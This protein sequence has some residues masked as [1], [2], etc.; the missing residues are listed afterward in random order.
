M[1]A[2]VFGRGS[3]FGKIGRGKIFG[4]GVGQNLGKMV[5]GEIFGM[6]GQKFWYGGQNL[7]KLVG[8]N[9]FSMKLKN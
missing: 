5:G 3:K 7:E 6:G 1:F 8:D 9:I 4:R 2:K